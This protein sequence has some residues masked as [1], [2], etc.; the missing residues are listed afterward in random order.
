MEARLLARQHGR[1]DDNMETIRKR[2]RVL[3]TWHQIR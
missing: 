2:F 3:L 1:T